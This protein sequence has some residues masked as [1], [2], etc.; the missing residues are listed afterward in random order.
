[1]NFLGLLTKK[2]KKKNEMPGKEEKVKQ[3]TTEYHPT[4]CRAHN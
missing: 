3:H 4:Q 2:K 1:M